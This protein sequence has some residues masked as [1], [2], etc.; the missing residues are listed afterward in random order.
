MSSNYILIEGR[1]VP[2]P[3][4]QQATRQKQS[5]CPPSPT[6]S[7]SSIETYISSEDGTNCSLGEALKDQRDFHFDM[8]NRW[9]EALI[10][11]LDDPIY[12]NPDE[13]TASSEMMAKEGSTPALM[14][15]V[16]FGLQRLFSRG[17]SKTG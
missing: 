4:D 17:N 2:V 7:I 15:F 11:T 5:H 10:T 8:S 14:P 1:F 12:P 16:G 13:P 6:R 3:E 9:K